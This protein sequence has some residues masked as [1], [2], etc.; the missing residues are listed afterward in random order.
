MP[1]TPFQDMDSSLTPVPQEIIDALVRYEFS[2]EHSSSHHLYGGGNNTSFPDVDTPIPETLSDDEY[3]K[4]LIELECRIL[5]TLAKARK[6]ALRKEFFTSTLFMI[7]ELEIITIIS[8][9]I[10]PSMF[11]GEF[12]MKEYEFKGQYKLNFQPSGFVINGGQ[13]EFPTPL[14]SVHVFPL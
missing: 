7:Q 9:F 12:L 11:N 1:Y 10:D 3:C 4:S 14:L 6:A 5:D 13:L 8:K 2:L